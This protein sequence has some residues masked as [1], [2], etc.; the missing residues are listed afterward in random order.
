M[1]KITGLER[2][3]ATRAD[4]KGEAYELTPEQ[5]AELQQEGIQNIIIG[6]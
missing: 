4:H 6:I 2:S 3:D 1:R 5:C